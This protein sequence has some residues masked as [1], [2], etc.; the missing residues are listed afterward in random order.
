VTL[1]GQVAVT[2]GPGGSRRHVSRSPN[3]PHN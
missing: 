3:A 1:I 2:L